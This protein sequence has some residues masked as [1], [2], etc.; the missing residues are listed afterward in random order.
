LRRRTWLARIAAVLSVVAAIALIALAA[1][2]LRSSRLVAHDDLSFDSAPRQAGLWDDIDVLPR[3]VTTRL[4]QLE[5]DLAYRRTVALF[6]RLRPGEKAQVTN[7]E[8]ENL[9]AKLQFELTTRSREDGD[10]RRRSD[11]QNLLGVLTLA[12]LAYVA[13]EGRAQVLTNALGSFRSAIELDPENDDAKLNLEL[14]MRL[15][16]PVLFPGEGLSGGAARGS[17][18][19]QG[20]SGS[21]Y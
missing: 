10:P 9:L 12:R 5:D 3:G 13:P 7:L 17:V 11:L 15:F 2:V 20:R 14:L 18:S 16:G 8:Q 1:A 6:T 19:G 4:L 21:G